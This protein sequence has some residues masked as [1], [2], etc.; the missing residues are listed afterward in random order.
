MIDIV[1]FLSV[2]P[3]LIVNSP[4]DEL[5]TDIESLT[6]NPPPSLV[7]RIHCIAFKKIDGYNP[8]LK[9]ITL[10]ESMSTL[11]HGVM[12][13]LTQLLFGDELAAEYLLCHLISS[14]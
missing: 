13:V 4:D 8:L 9:E 6:H 10:E 1:G 5:D 3:K 12:T 11:K 7:P 2:D 14:V